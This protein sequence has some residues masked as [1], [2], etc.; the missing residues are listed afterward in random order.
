MTWTVG[1]PCGLTIDIGPR[2]AIAPGDWIATNAGARYLVTAS[3][4]GNPRARHTQQVR[5]HLGVVRLDRDVDPPD[6]VRVWWMR[7]YPRDRTR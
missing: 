5:W 6:E 4:R 1:E 7:W 2:D 3:R